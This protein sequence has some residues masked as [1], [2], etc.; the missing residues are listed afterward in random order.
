MRK[1]LDELLCE[2]Y[3]KIFRDRHADMRVTAM[4]WGFDVGDGWFNII[5]QMCNLIQHHIDYSRRDR[6]RSLRFNRAMKRAL[7]GDKEPLIKL[8]TFGSN[9]KSREWAVDSVEKMLKRDVKFRE[10]TA[11]CPQVVALQVKEKFGTLRFYTS[12]GDQY[13]R[14]VESMADAMSSVTC[15]ECGNAGK[16][17]TTGWYRTLCKTH[18]EEF[19]YDWEIVDSEENDNE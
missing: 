7:A 6:A 16:L 19:N 10:P 4:C 17:L 9:E 11:A 2:R 13:T 8:H 1:E 15:E 12:G 3:P 18:A 14:G 5:N